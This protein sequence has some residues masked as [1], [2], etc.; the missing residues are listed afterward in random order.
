MTFFDPSPSN[1]Q[2]AWPFSHLFNDMF[3]VVEYRYDSKEE[4][5]LSSLVNNYVIGS[6][7]NVSREVRL[8]F[9]ET[10]RDEGR[11][12]SDHSATVQGSIARARDEKY[13]YEGLVYQMMASFVQLSGGNIFRD[14]TFC[15]LGPPHPQVDDAEGN[16][17]R[18]LFA[19][20]WD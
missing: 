17:L 5:Y 10:K 11:W 20:G 4:Y 2:E 14:K 1:F 16:R 19:E 9:I 6:D 18:S 13:F 3:V 15:Q 8:A 12:K 7:A